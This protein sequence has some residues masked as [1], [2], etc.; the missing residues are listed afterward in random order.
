MLPPI[1]N[2]QGY[3][4]N[5]KPKLPRKMRQVRNKQLVI[6]SDGEGY[7]QAIKLAEAYRHLLPRPVTNAQL[8]GLHNV[9]TSASEPAIVKRFTSNQGQ[10]AERRGDPELRD[11]WQTLG[12][13]LDGLR[14]TAG[15]LWGSIGGEGLGWTKKPTRDIHNDIQMRLMR[16]FAQHLVAHSMY[17]KP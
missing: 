7:Q 10:K 8:N 6:W 3:P 13:A 4:M 9:V 5:E 1:T 15:E 17:L 11:Y 16:A 12:K 2:M 14:K